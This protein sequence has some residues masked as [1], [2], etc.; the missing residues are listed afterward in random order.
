[1]HPTQ[2][3][4]APAFNI[5][6]Y[7]FNYGSEKKKKDIRRIIYCNWRTF[8]KF[9][10]DTMFPNISSLNYQIEIVNKLFTFFHINAL[11]GKIRSHLKHEPNYLE[12]LFFFWHWFLARQAARL[13]MYGGDAGRDRDW[14]HLSVSS[15]VSALLSWWKANAHIS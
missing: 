15:V 5:G 12:N 10:T 14:E 2:Y 4:P 11:D 1:V 13:P 9:S 3:I 6:Y 7:F 8:F